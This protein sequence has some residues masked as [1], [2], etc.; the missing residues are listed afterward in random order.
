MVGEWQ[1]RERGTD[2]SIGCVHIIRTSRLLWPTF[3]MMEKPASLRSL[4]VDAIT[5]VGPNYPTVQVG[6]NSNDE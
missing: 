6:N 4:F 5:H 3:R 1:E 2:G